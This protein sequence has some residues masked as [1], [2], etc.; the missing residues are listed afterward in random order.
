[1]ERRHLVTQKA[2]SFGNID[3][4]GPSELYSM[5][6]DNVILECRDGEEHDKHDIYADKPKQDAEKRLDNGQGE[7]H[8]KDLTKM[9]QQSNVQ[10]VDEF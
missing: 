10:M 4:L 5:Q 3:I 6:E 1:M 9:M 7:G 2:P 8:L